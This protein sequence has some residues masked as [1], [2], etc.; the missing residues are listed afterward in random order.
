[1]GVRLWNHY[2]ADTQTIIEYGSF[3]LYLVWKQQWSPWELVVFAE[4]SFHH[5]RDTKTHH[6]N[7]FPLM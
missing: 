6:K 1:M 3:R 7:Q 2:G 5:H 4:W